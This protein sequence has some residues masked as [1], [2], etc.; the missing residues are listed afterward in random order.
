RAA[1]LEGRCVPYGEANVWWPIAEALRQACSVSA[2]DP[3]NVAS[4][5]CT[6]AVSRAL[7]DDP[8]SPEVV[9][10]ASGL[11]HLMGYDA[12]LGE[13]DAQRARDEATR[14]VL[15]FVEASAR[16]RPVVIVLSDLHWAD[17]VVLEVVTVLADRLSRSRFVLV[18]T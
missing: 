13:I 7:D 3:L 2:D 14:A 4:E 10:I 8:S 17:D 16:R 1:V 18:A 11:L 15:D 6:E 5:R 9:R 12:P